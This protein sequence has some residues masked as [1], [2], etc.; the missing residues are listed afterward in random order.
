MKTLIWLDDIRDPEDIRMD[1]L[2]Y[3][4][5]GKAVEVIW[6]KNYSQ[7]KNWILENGL[8]DGI[9]FDHDLGEN[10]PSGYECAKWLVNFCL[11]NNVP[12]PVWSSQ[13]ANPVGK[14]NINR[15]LRN[16]LNSREK[17]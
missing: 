3:S 11:D 9:C 17:S 10:T 2:A 4:P 14:A 16:F 7:F 5:I 1:W 12:P 6:L 8:P 15:L 13:S